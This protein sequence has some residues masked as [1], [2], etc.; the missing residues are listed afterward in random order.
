MSIISIFELIV[1]FTLFEIVVCFDDKSNEGEDGK[2]DE[3][4]EEIVKVIL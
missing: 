1:L 2:D 3:L 4:D